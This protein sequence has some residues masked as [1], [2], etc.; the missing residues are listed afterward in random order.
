MPDDALRPGTLRRL[1]FTPLTDLLR[2]RLSGRLDVRARIDA[3]GLPAPALALV[4]RVVRRTRLWRAEKVDVA[5]ELAA[6]FA[7]GLE[8]GATVD[9]LVAAVY[10]DVPRHLWP[11]AAQST[12][13]A[14]VKLLA[15]GRVEGGI[16]PGAAVRR[17]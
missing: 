1:R 4:R 2:G 6:H 11:A 9:E 12:R 15:E 16:E 3:T 13:A 5:A 8:A 7:D 14:L 17:A 10:A